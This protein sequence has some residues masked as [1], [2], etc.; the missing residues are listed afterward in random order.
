[1][2]DSDGKLTGNHLDEADVSIIH[3]Q[4]ALADVEAGM[5]LSDDLL[6]GQG[7]VLLPQ[8][9][10]LTEQMIASLERHGIAS[11]RV[12]AGELTPE[13]EA[14]RHA[15]FRMRIE[16]LFRHLDDTPAGSTLRRYISTYRLSK[17]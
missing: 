3:R 14:E 2:A 10:I 5:M 13:Q 7:H 4:L 12:V 11:L 1:M 15:H 6:D 8:G 16:R 9:S 17:S